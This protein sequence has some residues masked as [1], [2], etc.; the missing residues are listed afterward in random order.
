[1]AADAL[2]LLLDVGPQQ[3]PPHLSPGGGPYLPAARPRWHRHRLPP[4]GHTPQPAVPLS[5]AVVRPEDPRNLRPPGVH[6]EPH[7][8]GQVFRDAG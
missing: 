7:T 3:A 2:R 4:L 8:T 6:K 5:Q 1:M